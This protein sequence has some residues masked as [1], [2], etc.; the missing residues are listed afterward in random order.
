MEY[1]ASQGHYEINGVIGPDEYKENVN[2][3]YYT[4]ALVQWHLKKTVEVCGLLEGWGQ[5][6]ALAAKIGL[7]EEEKADWLTVADQIKLARR[8]DGLLI[9]HD[10]FLDLKEI[11]VEY[12]KSLPGGLPSHISWEDVNKSQV[13]KQADSVMLLY[14][15]GDKFSHETKKVNWD[16]YEPRTMHDSSLSPAIHSI[17][18]TEMCDLESAYRYFSKS[19]RID[20]GN[21]MGNSDHG[22]HAATQGGIWQ[23]VVNGF[24]GMRVRDAVLTLA[25]DLPK[26]WKSLA[27][28]L[29]YCGACLEMSITPASAE[30]RCL[31]PGPAPVQV[32][33]YG[34]T[35]SF[36]QAGESKIWVK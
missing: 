15:L 25:P 21:N 33:V 13:L 14:L 2:N 30:I 8:E 17:L 11:D 6:D 27:F 12:Y 36:T 9:Q 34:E 31:T 23:A 7:T 20:L 19:A 32:Q 5:Y 4:N 28:K 29:N 3:N 16:F 22:L 10:G 35:V 18:A 26:E 24:A 1:N